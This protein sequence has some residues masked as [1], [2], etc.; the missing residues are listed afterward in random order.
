MFSPAPATVRTW[1]G[2]S[3]MVA[4]ARA[5]CT[6]AP[7]TVTSSV[8]CAELRSSH[9]ERDRRGADRHRHLVGDVSPG[10]DRQ[11]GLAWRQRERKPSGGVGD[12]AQ[13]A[14][15]HDGVEDR[16]HREGVEHAAAE[17]RLRCGLCRRSG[18]GWLRC[19]R[20]LN[21]RCGLWRASRESSLGGERRGSGKHE[22]Q[23]QNRYQASHHR[24]T[25]ARCLPA[26]G[27]RH[28]VRRARAPR[29][30]R[31]A[32]DGPSLRVTLA[33][34]TTLFIAWRRRSDRS[35]GTRCFGLPRSIRSS[36]CRAAPSARCRP[37]AGQSSGLGCRR[38]RRAPRLPR[39][40]LTC[41]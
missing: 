35:R 9:L 38:R 19:R 15:L 3:S 11:P 4:G 17:R 28:R 40:R 33:T 14:R 26:R 16:L 5:A 8:N 39:L 34:G 18:L 12:R 7:L 27:R 37:G 24:T 20:F 30:R 32:G 13:V 22:Q 1:S 21:G 2:L 25:S 6:A 41:R 29:R 23:G 31:G 36:R 10:G